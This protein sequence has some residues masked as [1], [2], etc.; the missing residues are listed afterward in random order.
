[1]RMMVTLSLS[2]S[3]ILVILIT[4]TIAHALHEQRS[5][6]RMIL[7]VSGDGS[8]SPLP[9]HK[10]DNN[11]AYYSHQNDH[12]HKVE[13]ILERDAHKINQR[14][15][16]RRYRS[17]S[18]N[19]LKNE[20]ESIFEDLPLEDLVTSFHTQYEEFLLDLEDPFHPYHHFHD[21]QRSSRELS[22]G[23]T[24]SL[25]TLPVAMV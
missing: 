9:S 21:L 7:D 4:I 8:L 24:D 6:E 16:P 19:K 12:A 13:A 1:M 10:S 5:N 11:D 18:D 3:L 22:V 17:H 23:I 25:Q 20:V 2:L 14:Y 15:Q